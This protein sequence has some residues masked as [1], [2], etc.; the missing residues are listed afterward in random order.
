MPSKAYKQ[1]KARKKRYEENNDT[2]RAN[3]TKQYSS[4]KE[5]KLKEAKLL[6]SSDAQLRK[7]HSSA[8]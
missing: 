6:W 7:K 3:S 2:A 8:S 4:S 1:R 5:T